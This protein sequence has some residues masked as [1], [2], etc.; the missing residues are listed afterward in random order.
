[1]AKGWHRESRRHSLASR[2]IKTAQK[3]KHIPIVKPRF[4]KDKKVVDY[5]KSFLFSKLEED[6]RF[7]VK[8][9][10][11]TNIYIRRFDKIDENKKQLHLNVNL[12]YQTLSEINSEYDQD[13]SGFREGNKLVVSY[14]KSK[15]PYKKYDFELVDVKKIGE[16]ELWE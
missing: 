14:K 8:S 15:N 11:P 3:I 7:S 9:R 16:F 4:V 12:G 13:D 5:L 6:K 2:G 10:E 1:M